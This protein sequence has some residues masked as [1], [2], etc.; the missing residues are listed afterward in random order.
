MTTAAPTLLALE[1]DSAWVVILAVSLFTLPLVLLLRRLISRPGGFASGLLLI[2]PLVLPLVAAF[3]YQHAV[4]PEIAVLKPAGAALSEGSDGLLHLLL[5]GHGEGRVF[6][7]YALTGSAGRYLLLFGLTVSSL[8]LLRRAAG[9]LMLMR[10]VRR[11]ERPDPDVHDVVLRQVARL[12]RRAGLKNP[13]ELL[14]LPPGMIGAFAA[15]GGGGRILMSEALIADLEEDETEAILAHE[16]AHLKSKDVQMVALAGTLRDVVAWNPIAHIAYRRFASHREYE[17]DRRAA[18][19]VGSPLSV[20]SGLL[21]MCDLI[22]ATG[23]RGQGA[24]A[25]LRPGR[26]VKRRVTAL[27]ALAD[28]RTSSVSA[29]A[30]P[31]VAAAFLVAVLGLQVGARIAENQGALAIMWGGPD[32]ADTRTWGSTYSAPPSGE[33]KSA[34]KKT[35]TD[36]LRKGSASSPEGTSL[37]FR[38]SDLDPLL[39]ELSRIA[40]HTEQSAPFGVS[41]VPTNWQA[42]PLVSEANSIGLYRINQLR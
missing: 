12:S 37:S 17:A 8:M 7:P 42:V 34:G 2:L 26:R 32:A 21:K 39:A 13:P 28:G 33:L 36:G 24:L 31:Y 1:T 30:L 3:V 15:G 40:R 25:F 20:A 41:Q 11:C 19:L 22:R 14:L 10:L 29:G 27:L 18:A 6:T 38:S 16:I 5:V 4:L 23:R 9:K 35:K